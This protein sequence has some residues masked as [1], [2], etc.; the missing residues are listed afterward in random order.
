MNENEVYPHE[1]PTPRQFKCNVIS[2]V[3]T[4][5]RVILSESLDAPDG[6]QCVESEWNYRGIF[7]GFTNH[8]KKSFDQR[9][10]ELELQSQDA[11]K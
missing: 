8:R 11:E 9:K 1:S 5:K 7:T 6:I 10:A 4:L 3:G 2:S